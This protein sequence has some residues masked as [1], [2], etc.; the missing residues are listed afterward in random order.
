LPLIHS[1]KA[2]DDLFSE[3]VS[4]LKQ[5]IAFFFSWLIAKTHNQQAGWVRSAKGR[6]SGIAL[7]K[8]S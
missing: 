4:A 8:T 2:N 3:A 6:I 5:P 1:D 7:A